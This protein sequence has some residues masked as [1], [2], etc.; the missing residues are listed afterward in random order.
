MTQLPTSWQEVEIIEVLAPNDNG[1][2]FQ[3]GWSPQCER[4]P[5]PDGVWGV[6]KTTAIQHGEF[7][8]HENKALPDHLE[9]RP[10]IEVKVGDV[11]MTCAGP[12]NR[13]GVACLV[14]QT[15]PRL[16][17]SGK[18][19]RFRPHPDGLSP[20]YLAYLFQRHDT[21][22][23]I[24]RMKTGIS[25][26]GLN[27]T[28]DRLSALLV[29]LAP[30]REQHR[31]V[32]KIEELSSELDKAVES[33]TLARAQLK[34][35][36]Q[37]LLKAAF[38]G[39]LTA[40]WRVA[41]PDKLESPK[42]LLARIRNE[43]EA[44]YKEALAD[45]QAT[46]AEWRNGGERGRKPTKPARPLEPN[47]V[48]CPKSGAELPAGWGFFKVGNLCEVVRGGSPR[49]AG[50]AKF[51]GGTIPFLKVADLTRTPGMRVSG[52]T[53]TITE[54]G[55][56]KTRETPPNT[57][58]I[59]N[60]GA[61]LGVPKVCVIRATFNDGIAAF[62]GL[63]TEELAFHYYFWESKTAALRGL[64]QGAAQPNLNTMI[65]AD[66]EIPMCSRAEAHEIVARLS[67]QISQVEAMEREV[68]LSMQKA[69]ILLESILNKAFTG[70]L[71]PQDPTD[72]PAPALLAR[73]RQ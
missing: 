20:K 47:F 41:N 56:S 13:C 4:L 58:M 55:L 10:Q 5:A 57:L 39:K 61:T 32:A 12:R 36:R 15:R 63:A 43:R 64:N 69:T 44:R 62:L 7:W 72:E 52:Y 68:D 31:I 11:V 26:S 60:S 54:A 30:L 28:H 67:V 70:Q 35:Y 46:L 3:Q 50:D 59:S 24:D 27:L 48:E 14:E 40:D 6:L 19:Y 25:D 33:L 51:Y 38:E 71:V 16:M 65:L 73:L 1:R 18:M 29:P 66:V 8:P 42:A 53:Y 34:A 9:P 23:K 2:P 22:L 49:P 45:W 17:L 37:S 21:Q